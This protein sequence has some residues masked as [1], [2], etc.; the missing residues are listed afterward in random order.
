MAGRGLQPAPIPQADDTLEH[1]HAHGWL[2]VRQ[3][4]SADA[5]ARMQDVAWTGLEE[6]G[7]R[8]DAPSTWTVERPARLQRLKAH[9]AFAAIGSERLLAAVEAILGTRDYDK[10]RHWGAL[11]VAFPGEQPFCVPASG[12]HVDANYRSQ[13]TPP[14]GVQI[15][16]LFGE[17]APRSGATLVVSG[18]HRLIHRWFHEH[19]AP[20]DAR[21]M[22]MRKLLLGHPYMRDL[23]T[24]GAA[25]VRIARFM[26]RVEEVDGVPLQVIE[27]LGAAGDVMLLHPLLMH[28][29]APN[30]GA[31]PRFL[32]S[33]S[34]TT[35]MAG[36]G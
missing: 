19:P 5:A 35:D 24:E 1:F 18:S 32:L 7:I 31:A 30:A 10:P 6:A 36:W 17:V 22:D 2:R 29:A 9:P 33:G 4:F 15:H 11:F 27:N 3:A 14:K 21:S 25:E 28:V 16:A 26:E 34:I 8:R 20:I 23:H 13:L 12:W